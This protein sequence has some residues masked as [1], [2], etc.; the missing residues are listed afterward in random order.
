MVLVLG[1]IINNAHTIFQLVHRI[2]HVETH[3]LMHLKSRIMKQLDFGWW[4]GIIS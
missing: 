1:F 2:D 4:L 3:K